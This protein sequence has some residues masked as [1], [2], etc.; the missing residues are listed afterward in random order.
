[1]VPTMFNMILNLPP[2]QRDP[3]DVS[4]VR[5]LL[6]AA[7]P[8]PTRVKESILEFFP[9][10]GLFE[11]YGFTE[12][13]LATVLRPEDQLRKIRCVGL[14]TY[15]LDLRI[16]DDK[17]NE[18]PRGQ[19][20]LIYVKCSYLMKE[21]HRN[22]DATRAAFRDSWLT[23]QDVGK[24]DEEGYLYVVDRKADMVIS[25]GVNI[26][27]LE[28]EEVLLR[29]PKVLEAAVIG[30][31]DEKW[32]EALLAVV[33]PK[34]G[35]CLDTEEILSFCEGKMARFKIPRSVELADELPKSPAG[36]VLK[37]VLREPFW[38]GREARI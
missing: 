27:P 19:E 32:G 29:H 16:L 7:A 9:K 11:F 22:P 28:I 25:G 21:Y 23:A 3:Y 15:F 36:K 17:G 20:G 6:S 13:G 33:V 4:S 37:R 35:V 14:P 30:I 34:P 26:Y 8:L 18:V 10:A 24:L 1:M 5:V 12:V 31:P 2:E 38:K